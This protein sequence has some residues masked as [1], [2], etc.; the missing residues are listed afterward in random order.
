MFNNNN[1]ELPN[2]NF[3]GCLKQAITHKQFQQIIDDML[4][5]MSIVKEGFCRRDH[6]T[7]Q[8]AKN[9]LHALL[10]DVMMDDTGY[11]LDKTIDESKKEM[12]KLRRIS[13]QIDNHKRI[14][15][16]KKA[17]KDKLVKT[18]EFC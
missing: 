2:T 15:S 16:S 9:Q 5:G 11:I 10:T 8:E 14:A 1:P 3:M 7:L 6:H 17:N 13:R 18:L 12:A 4:R